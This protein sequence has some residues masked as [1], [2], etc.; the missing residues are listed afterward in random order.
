MDLLF[1][2]NCFTCKC[3]LN[4]FFFFPN[5]R[6]FLFNLLFLFL[7]KNLINLMNFHSSKDSRNYR[8]K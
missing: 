1:S 3:N 5:S 2:I 7:K 8:R 4:L 6:F